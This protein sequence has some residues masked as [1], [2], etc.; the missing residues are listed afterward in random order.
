MREEF[1]QRTFKIKLLLNCGKKYKVTGKFYSGGISHSCQ[2]MNLV[3][4]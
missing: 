1:D 3:P 4:C 2:S